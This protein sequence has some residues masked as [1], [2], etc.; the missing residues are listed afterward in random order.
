MIA[1]SARLLR[2]YVFPRLL[3]TDYARPG[4]T[5]LL[6]LRKMSVSEP[7]SYREGGGGIYR[8]WDISDGFAHSVFTREAAVARRGR[9]SVEGLSEADAIQRIERLL[10]EKASK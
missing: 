5:Y 1:Q 4:R 8:M 7:D 6:I 10:S 2:K 3:C 9:F